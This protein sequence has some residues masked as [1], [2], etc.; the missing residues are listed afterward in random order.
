L[1]AR[2]SVSQAQS[3]ITPANQQNDLDDVT[4]IGRGHGQ[5][6][7]S[8]RYTLDANQIEQ[9]LRADLLNKS[10]WKDFDYLMLSRKS[11][12][13]SP[14]LEESRTDLKSPN[15]GRKM[16]DQNILHGIGFG[17]LWLLFLPQNRMQSNYRFLGRQKMYGHESYVVAFAQSPDR[18]KLPGEI[19][20]L[21]T[22]YPLLYQGI[23]WIDAATFRIL[24]L[25]ADLLAPLP[26]IQ[27]QW[28]SSD[29]RFDE[30]RI[31]ELDLPLWLP[32]QVE[33]M[34]QQ[35]DQLFG[36]MHLYTQYRLFHATARI[37]PP[38]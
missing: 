37:L 10:P 34:W 28:L 5:T 31:P 20:F 32:R 18:V 2:E 35:R 14:T 3:T 8:F 26:G 38:H 27:L 16:R 12:D 13:G 23:A 25:E 7:S 15:P 30:V 9:N 4:F 29:L 33:L 36:E 21:G 17:Y 6:Q 24:R 19:T 22:A 11:P 1:T